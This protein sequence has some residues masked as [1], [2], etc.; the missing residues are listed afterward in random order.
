MLKGARTWTTKG[1][2]GFVINVNSKGSCRWYIIGFPVNN[3][4]WSVEHCVMNP[5]SQHVF[6]WVCSFHNSNLIWDNDVLHQSNPFT[7]CA[8]SSGV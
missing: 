3:T 2:F 5:T 6:L 8:H 7:H 1:L 4:H